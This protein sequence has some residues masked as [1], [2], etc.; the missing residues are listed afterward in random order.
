M[1]TGITSLLI[2]LFSCSIN[3]QNVNIPDVN[4]KA[5]LL[6][7]LAIN[8]NADTEIQV[9]EASVFT[10]PLDCSDQSITDLT[11]VDWTIDITSAT[12]SGKYFKVKDQIFE[13]VKTEGN[14][15]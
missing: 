1:N 3:A 5:Y 15:I 7:N 12:L 8:T 14:A 4:F 11:G 13:A 6:G 2:I 9:G 10:G